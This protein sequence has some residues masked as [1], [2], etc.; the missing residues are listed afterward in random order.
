MLPTVSPSLQ[1]RLR[2]FTVLLRSVAACPLLTTD[3]SMEVYYLMD[4]GSLAA[5]AGSNRWVP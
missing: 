5:T 2:E 1:K 3:L 4:V